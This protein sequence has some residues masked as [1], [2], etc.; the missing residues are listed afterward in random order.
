MALGSVGHRHRLCGQHF[1]AIQCNQIVDDLSSHQFELMGRCSERP[2]LPK[3][4]FGLSLFYRYALGVC[5]AF[6]W[7]DISALLAQPPKTI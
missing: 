1:H 4:S 5:L 6:T 7:C 3:L 2:C